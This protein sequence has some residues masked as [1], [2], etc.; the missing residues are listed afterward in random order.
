[1]YEPLNEPFEQVRVWAMEAHLVGTV[2]EED[3]YAVTEEPLASVPPHGRVQ[4]AGAF[5]LAEHIGLHEPPFEPEQSHADW[6]PAE[7]KT[8]LL[9]DPTEH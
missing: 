2:A 4:E 8:V 7:G 5:W 6:L 9:E 3:W 1:M